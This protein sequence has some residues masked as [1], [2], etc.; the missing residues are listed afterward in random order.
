MTVPIGYPG[1]YDDAKSAFTVSNGGN[2]V[3]WS[4]PDPDPLA[5]E[6]TIG[7]V[8]VSARLRKFDMSKF[9]LVSRGFHW[10]SE[11]PFNR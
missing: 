8:P 1:K 9:V 7:G 2:A 10:I 4:R 11:F 6:C 3:T 5:I